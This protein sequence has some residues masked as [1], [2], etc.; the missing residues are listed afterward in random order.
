MTTGKAAAQVGHASMLL[1][2]RQDLAWV[3]AWA[4]EGFELDVREVPHAQFA[5][6]LDT[7]GVVTVRDAGYTEVAPDALT[8]LAVP[9]D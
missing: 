7:P 8:V 5:E 9:G 3:R 2:A 6:H 4:A 1:A